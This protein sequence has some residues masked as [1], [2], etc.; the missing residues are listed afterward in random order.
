MQLESLDI[1]PQY[2]I[3]TH[4]H[5]AHVTGLLALQER[6][7]DACVVAGHGAY[8]F[9][10]HPKALDVMVHE[11][12]FMSTKL[13][14]VGIQPGRSPIDSFS[15]SE[16][17]IVVK[18][19]YEIDLGGIKLNCIKVSGHSP[20]NIVVHIPAIDSLVL[21][22]SLGF[23]YPG[24]G[25]LPL[26]LTDYFDYVYTLEYL[27]SLNPKIVGLGHQGAITGLSVTSAFS[28]SRQAT[29]SLLDRI[30]DERKGVDELTEEIFNEYYRDD[31]TMYSD[32]NIREVA[33][34]LV[35]RGR[36][37]TLNLT[38]RVTR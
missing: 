37:A 1:S 14:R 3:M 2:L 24:R 23:Y 22:D 18:D 6:Y 19:E 29:Y 20:G 28:D 21:S 8:N 27:E 36:E 7:P 13:S 32:R 35:R 30:L 38:W 11:D 10:T 34:L 4:P 15:F 31:F 9:L 33:Q 26:F 25:F 12:R 16:N 17:H 5:A